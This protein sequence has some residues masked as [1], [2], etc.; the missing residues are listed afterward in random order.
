MYFILNTL[1]T[2]THVW[3]VGVLTQ[4]FFRCI[5]RRETTFT[6]CGQRVW[7]VSIYMRGWLCHHLHNRC[8]CI[9][10]KTQCV[11]PHRTALD[12]GA[13]LCNQKHFDRYHNPFS[14]Q[15]RGNTSFI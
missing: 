4:W 7:M 11:R 3:V 14:S 13:E 15:S 5:H 2:D 9:V 8:V 10:N 1:K 6:W 12:L